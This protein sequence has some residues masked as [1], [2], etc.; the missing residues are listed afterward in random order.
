MN[1][2]ATLERAL[3]HL[4]KANGILCIKLDPTTMAGLPDRLLIDPRT[5]RVAFWELKTLTGKVSKVQ[6]YTHHTLREAGQD[7][8]VSHGSVQLRNMF[9][10]WVSDQ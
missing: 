8:F 9:E 1:N 3:R 4:C 2:E 5:G 10:A 7:V 6:H